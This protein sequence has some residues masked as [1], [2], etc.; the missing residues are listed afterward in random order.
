MNNVMTFLFL[1]VSLL[2]MASCAPNILTAADRGN[3]GA[4]D[5]A[6]SRGDDVN[7]KD[8]NGNTPLIL[9]AKHG[10]FD[11]V[12]KL[13][14][15]GANIKTKNNDGYDALLALSNYR[16]Q[17][18]PAEE[19]DRQASEPIPI[20]TEGHLKTA[21]YLIQ[22]GANVNEMTNEGNNALILASDLNKVKL[23]EL[24]LRKGADVNA[25]NKQGETALI[26]ASTKG[27]AELVC[28]LRRKGADTDMRD[29]QGKTALQYAK[30]Y[31]R[32]DI[33]QLLNTPCPP[34]TPDNAI[35]PVVGN[36]VED[37]LVDKFIEALTDKEP[38]VRWESA[39]R[40][41]DLKD[42]RAVV[43][44]IGA[45]SDGH[46]YVRRRAAVALG[47]LQ[48]P[49]AI[50]PLIKALQDDDSFVQKFASE[51]LEK[52]TGQHFGNDSKK[53]AEWWALKI[54]QY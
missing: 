36:K 24:L 12:K 39:R 29:N 15:R 11:V 18:S 2:E 20:T 53:W 30:Q 38:S 25:I 13:V 45:L 14:I 49:R 17:Y 4:V 22:N 47:E 40:L 28:P 1:L 48:D 44:L 26:V 43:P 16:M 8:N 27:Y 10:D 19:K 51:A 37:R 31:D 32:R 42:N 21:E 23:V 50:D 7:I 3:V 6:I 46:A 52:I 34:E 5:K 41:G 35:E 54:R 9:A 33:I